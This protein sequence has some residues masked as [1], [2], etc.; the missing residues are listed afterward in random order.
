MFSLL[1]EPLPGEVAAAIAER[2]VA[3]RKERGLSQVA[4]AKASGVSLGSLRRFEQIHEIS[5]GSLLAIAFALGCE[6]DFDALF[7]TPH[8]N[9]LEDVMAAT[10]GARR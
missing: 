4:L 9:T 7:A 5:L 8:Y 1:D 6:A 3:R 2:M 10:E